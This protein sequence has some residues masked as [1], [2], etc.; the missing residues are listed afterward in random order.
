MAEEEGKCFDMFDTS[1][2]GIMFVESSALNASNVSTA[3]EML[4]GSIYK[5]LNE[6]MFDDRL[7]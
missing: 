2:V 3:F 5:N 4:V 6:G 1:Y 7:D